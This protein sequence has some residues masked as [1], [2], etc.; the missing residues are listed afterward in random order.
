MLLTSLVSLNGAIQAHNCVL[1]P[2]SKKS[3]KSYINFLRH[4]KPEQQPWKRTTANN[5]LSK[6]AVM[7]QTVKILQYVALLT[8][9]TNIPPLAFPDH[10]LTLIGEGRD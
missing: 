5:M 1:K 2:L 6:R 9:M 3:C 8:S 10:Y 7:K 4:N